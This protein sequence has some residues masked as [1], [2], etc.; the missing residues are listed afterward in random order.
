[1]EVLHVGRSRAYEAVKH[2]RDVLDR[3]L[4]DDET[5]DVVY[6]AV[7]ERCSET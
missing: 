3:L 1:M 2:L 5:R 7:V 4:P 6:A